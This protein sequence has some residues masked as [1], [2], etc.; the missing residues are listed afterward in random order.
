MATNMVLSYIGGAPVMDQSLGR[1][2]PTAEQ[3][4]LSLVMSFPSK[5]AFEVQFKVTAAIPTATRI[6]NFLANS[7]ASSG[8]TN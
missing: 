7:A 5:K 3:E 6:L 4:M 1:T 8:F 2:V